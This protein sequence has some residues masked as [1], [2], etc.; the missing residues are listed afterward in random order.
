MISW[1]V[2]LPRSP[3]KL[4]RPYGLSSNGFCTVSVSMWHFMKDVKELS[5]ISQVNQNVVCK[6]NLV[7]V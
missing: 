4:E 5:L 6:F 7:H 1:L 3:R 2:V